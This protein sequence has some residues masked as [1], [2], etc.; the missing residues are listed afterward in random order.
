MILKVN[1]NRKV[2]Q[3]NKKW[4]KIQSFTTIN[5]SNLF[6]TILTFTFSKSTALKISSISL[7]ISP[8]KAINPLIW[9]HNNSIS[10]KY[11]S[12]HMKSIALLNPANLPSSSNLK[13]SSETFS[14]IPN[15]IQKI[16]PITK[17][18]ITI[19]LILHLT[20]GKTHL[21]QPIPKISLLIKTPSI[22]IKTHLKRLL[23][24]FMI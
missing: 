12:N 15:S 16:K 11:S 17:Q 3:N 1:S 24:K 19:F 22:L 5:P 18:V 13:V 10:H 21:T 6:L 14:S 23:S 4:Q 7:K 9:I 8:L 2:W 20:A